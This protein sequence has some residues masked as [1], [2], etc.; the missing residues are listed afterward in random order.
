MSS[1]I[2]ITSL[3]DIYTGGFFYLFELDE[4]YS[5]IIQLIHKSIDSFSPSMLGT[6]SSSL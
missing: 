3:E 5:N 1:F 2:A 6:I 4:Y